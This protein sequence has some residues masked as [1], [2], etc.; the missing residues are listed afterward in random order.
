MCVNKIYFHTI[1]LQILVLG[2][3]FIQCISV[4]SKYFV[5]RVANGQRE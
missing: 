1:V 4:L 2:G 5:G 3:F